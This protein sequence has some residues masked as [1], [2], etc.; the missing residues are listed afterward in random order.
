MIRNVG[1]LQIVHRRCQDT[2]Y[3]C[4][5]VSLTNNRCHLVRQIDN[6]ITMVRMSVVPADKVGCRLRAWQIL[7]Q[8]AQAEIPLGVAGK[9]D[10]M[11]ELLKIVDTDRRSDFDVTEEAEAV[12]AGYSIE[13][14]A[15]RLYLWVIWR[16]P[17]AHQAKG[18]RKPVKHVDGN[19]LA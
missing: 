6:A 9:N 2:T 8:N 10:R 13:D 16:N 18:R 3:I 1:L 14:L 17:A 7:S 4:S 5:H 15:D 12:Q 19:G 11:I